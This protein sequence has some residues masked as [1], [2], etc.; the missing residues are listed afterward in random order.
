MQ[1]DN[2]SVKGLKLKQNLE[3]IESYRASDYCHEWKVES[4]VRIEQMV[5]LL[6]PISCA[7]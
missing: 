7:N 3:S 5:C 6:S 4:I 2:T 1:Y